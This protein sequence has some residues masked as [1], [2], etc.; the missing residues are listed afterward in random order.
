LEGGANYIIF[1]VSVDLP[2]T[3]FVLELKRGL[4]IYLVIL[5]SFYGFWER[6]VLED[7]P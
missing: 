1:N 4:F 5:I 7:F 6:L 2:S 3:T